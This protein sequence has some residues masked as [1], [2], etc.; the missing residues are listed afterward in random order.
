MVVPAGLAEPGAASRSIPAICRSITDLTDQEAIEAGT[1]QREIASPRD[2]GANERI[3]V[4]DEETTS[5]NEAEPKSDQSQS[6]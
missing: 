3:E 2:L 4:N 1:G 6:K 5:E